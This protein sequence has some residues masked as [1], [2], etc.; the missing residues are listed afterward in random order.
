MSHVAT[1]LLVPPPFAALSVGTAILVE[2]VVHRRPLP[3][4]AFNTAS[5]VLT[6]SLACFAVGP[7]GDLRT[8]VAGRAAPRAGHGRRRRLP[9]LL[10]RQRHPDERDHGHRDGP[11]AGLSAAPERPEHVP[12]RGRGGDG[13]GRVRADLDRRA[14]LD[15]PARDARR[16]HHPRAPVHPPAGARD[17]LGRAQPGRSRRPPRCVDLPP[18]GAGRR[19]RGRSSPRARAGRGARR[20]HP[21]GRR[22]PRPRQDRHPRP[23]PAQVRP[24]TRARSGRRCGSTRR[25]GPGS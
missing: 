16:R 17:A 1:I 2:E 8:L 6:V 25:S 19:L 24:A 9:R 21:A 4:I 7:F 15:G 11:A 10:P 5:Y 18:F 3:R 23:D 22:G 14:A 20:A 12:R 13:R